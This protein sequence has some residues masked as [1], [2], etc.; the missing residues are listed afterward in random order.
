MSASRSSLCHRGAIAAVKRDGL[1]PILHCLGHPQLWVDLIY[2]FLMS[3]ALGFPQPKGGIHMPQFILTYHGGSQPATPEEGKA[4]RARYIAWMRELDM[5][6]GQQ[7]LKNTAVLGADQIGAPM[8]GYSI[9][10]AAD[11]D[12]ALAIAEKCPF[13]EMENATM[14]VSELVVMG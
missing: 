8:M 7:P 13:L 11:L 14:Q 4:H 1:K 6:V 9:L 10:N 3:G 12:E 2:G 5:V